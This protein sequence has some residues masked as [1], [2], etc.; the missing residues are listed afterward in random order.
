MAAAPCSGF[1]ELLDEA[2]SLFP[3]RL[4]FGLKR[5]THAGLLLGQNALGLQL[6]GKPVFQATEKAPLT[7]RGLRCFRPDLYAEPWELLGQE[8][9]RPTLQV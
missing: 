5:L 7:F 3:S 1:A 8:P 2:E 6:G 9:Q 4:P